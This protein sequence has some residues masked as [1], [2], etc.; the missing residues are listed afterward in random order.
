[1]K[2]KTRNGAECYPTGPNGGLVRKISGEHEYV[3]MQMLPAHTQR[4]EWVREDNIQV[5]D[6]RHENGK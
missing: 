4:I 1:M 6:D 2:Y 5:I 3:Q